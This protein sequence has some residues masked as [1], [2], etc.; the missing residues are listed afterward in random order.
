MQDTAV[1]TSTS[2]TPLHAV[3]RGAPLWVMV[4]N[5]D[6]TDDLHIGSDSVDA[7][8][9]NGITLAPGE[10]D[11]FCVPPGQILYAAASANTPVAGVY[12]VRD[13]RFQG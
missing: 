1:T 13:A 11:Y 3:D 4:R 10:R 12:A 7:D 8:Q 6:S 9:G 5:N 2:A